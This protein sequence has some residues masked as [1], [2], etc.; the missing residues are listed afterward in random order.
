M[1]NFHQPPLSQTLSELAGR[2]VLADKEGPDRER[3]HQRALARPPSDMVG[4]AVCG[5]VR[6][7]IAKVVMVESEGI[8]VTQRRLCRSVHTVGSVYTRF[9]VLLS[10]L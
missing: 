4:L 2:F 3:R 5:T 9:C 1:L 7:A 8:L 6:E 10:K